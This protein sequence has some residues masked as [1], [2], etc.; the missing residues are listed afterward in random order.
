MLV[1][2]S[3]GSTLIKLT[4]SLRE[5]QGSVRASCSIP[6]LFCKT[7][8]GFPEQEPLVTLPFSV[9]YCRSSTHT[10]SGLS[11]GCCQHQHGAPRQCCQGTDA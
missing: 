5:S 11:Q 7:E 1:L 10:G 8:T 3:L 9:T 4:G 6:H 2:A